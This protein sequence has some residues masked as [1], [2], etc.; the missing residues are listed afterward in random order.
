MIVVEVSRNGT[1]FEDSRRIGRVVRSGKNYRARADDG[2]MTPP[3]ADRVEAAL[4]LS[5]LLR[6]ESPL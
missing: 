1:I 2:T 4:C 5:R 3:Y 6:G